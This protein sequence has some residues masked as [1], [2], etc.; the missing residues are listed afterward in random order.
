MGTRCAIALFEGSQA[1]D[2]LILQQKEADHSS[3][4]AYLTKRDY[5]SQAQRV[6]I[7]QRLIQASSD[8]FLGWHKAPSG[9]QYYWRQLKDMKGSFDVTTF[10]ADGLGACLA[11]CG[12][13]LARAHARAGDPVAISGYMGSSDNFDKAISKFAMAY[14]DQT[15]KDYQALQDAVSSGRIVAKTGV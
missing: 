7:G 6:V 5:D 15:E 9:T 1:G 13:C 8:I 14:A 3:L 11:T 4:E 10:D 12:T 2:A